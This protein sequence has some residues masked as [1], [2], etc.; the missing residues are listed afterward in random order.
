MEIPNDPVFST[1]SKTGA[2]TYTTSEVAYDNENV[3][4]AK[5]DDSGNLHATAFI[6][7]ANAFNVVQAKVIQ[8]HLHL[9]IPEQ[10]KILDAVGSNKPNYK[11]RWCDKS[12]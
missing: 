7:G 1:L 12:R 11:H 5:R 9:L 2:G 8:T 10:G 4:I 6:V 3:S